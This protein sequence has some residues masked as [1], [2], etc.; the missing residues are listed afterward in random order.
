MISPK[1]LAMS[2]VHGSEQQM[3][4]LPNSHKVVW[5]GKGQARVLSFQRVRRAVIGVF[6]FTPVYDKSLVI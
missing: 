5:T 4:A 3:R 1:L 6:D 2:I